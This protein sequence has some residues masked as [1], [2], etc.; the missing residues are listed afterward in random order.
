M[1]LMLF[2]RPM[3]VTT[4]MWTPQVVTPVCAEWNQDAGSAQGTIDGLLSFPQHRQTLATLWRAFLSSSIEAAVC[5]WP[6]TLL[7]G[8]SGTQPT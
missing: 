6:L 3:I 1:E 4:M 5:C 2:D 8:S 7:E